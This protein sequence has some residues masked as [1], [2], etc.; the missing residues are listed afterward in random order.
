MINNDEQLEEEKPVIIYQIPETI[1]TCIPGNGLVLRLNCKFFKDNQTDSVAIVK[2]DKASEELSEICMIQDAL[3]TFINDNSLLA[4]DEQ[5]ADTYF[6]RVSSF[7]KQLGDYKREENFL[8]QIK[9]QE[10]PTYKEAIAENGLRKN[11]NSSENLKILYNLNTSSSIKKLT[12]FYMQQEEMQKAEEAFN[13]YFS[14]HDEPSFELYFQYSFFTI[15]NNEPRK[16]IRYLKKAFY[17]SNNSA[18]AANALSILYLQESLHNKRLIKKALFWLK[19]ACFTDVQY[20]PSLSFLTSGLIEIDCDFV[21]KQLAQF[22][23]LASSNKSSFYFDAQNNFAFCAYKQNKI[24]DCLERLQPIV[25]DAADGATV[26]NNIA[27]C[28]YRQ[29]DFIRAER[30]IEK[31]LHK[32]SFSNTKKE[33]T[34]ETILSNYMMILNIQGKFTQTKKFFEKWNGEASFLPTENNYRNYFRQYRIAL[35]STGENET[36][37]KFLKAFFLDSND[38]QIKLFACYDIINFFTITDVI[39]HGGNL[40]VQTLDFMLYTYRKNVNIKNKNAILNNIVFLCL[41]LK[42]PVPEDIFNTFRSILSQSPFSIAT[43]GLYQF[44]IMHN[45][46]K[47]RTCYEKAITE[48][49]SLPEVSNSVLNIQLKMNLETAREYLFEGGTENIND[50]RRL[51]KSV[52]KKSDLL[53]A[54]YRAQAK[55]LLAE[56]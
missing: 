29:K 54:G 7:Y 13:H 37:I 1:D 8:L 36:Y 20:V 42:E 47:G 35:R 14:E 26:W 46:Q 16:A 4:N 11:E 27:L 2:N 15:Q 41:E 32:Y 45:L 53:T 31:A 28:N 38:S 40:V 34:L 55:Q 30:N 49:R 56:C 6:Y 23:A 12:G 17:V 25:Q 5:S 52:I 21:E 44:R 24:T 33:P 39:S 43:W 50:A 19:T 51:L 18:A 3:Q 10:H 48:A 9:N 22:L